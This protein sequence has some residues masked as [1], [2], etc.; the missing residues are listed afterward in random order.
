MMAIVAVARNEGS[1]MAEPMRT[2]RVNADSK[3]VAVE[4][5]PNLEPGPGHV[6]VKL[7]PGWT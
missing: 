6:L 2:H 3:T 1:D 5:V 4:D 7:G